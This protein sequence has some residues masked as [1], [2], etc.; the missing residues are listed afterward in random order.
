MAIQKGFT[1]LYH[2][3]VN[4]DNLVTEFCAIL[5]LANIFG[6]LV[7]CAPAA[8]TALTLED[9]ATAFTLEDGATA[10]VLEDA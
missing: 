3:M 7:N 6:S 2:A 5:G 10:L 8:G 4:S 1:A 9:V